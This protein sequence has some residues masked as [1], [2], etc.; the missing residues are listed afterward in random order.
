MWQRPSRTRAFDRGQPMSS[1]DRVLIVVAA[2]GTGL[3]G[4][5]FL[6]FST[7][8]MAA[9]RRLPAR[10]GLVAMQAINRAAPSPG[11]MTL[12]FGTAA[13]CLAVAVS[14]LPDLGVAAGRYQL[15]GAAAYLVAIVV[16]V[17]YHVPRNEALGAVDP[18]RPDAA[19]AW[20]RYAGP[21]TAWNHLRSALCL[22][23]ALALTAA[24]V[25]G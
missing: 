15:A 6:A 4:G 9:L 25:A 11:F 14:A 10:D 21:W 5:A 12:L 22:A 24:L 2:I 19:D 16:T 3:A 7:F 8:V 23:G 1:I 13:A 20:R 17:T 18:A